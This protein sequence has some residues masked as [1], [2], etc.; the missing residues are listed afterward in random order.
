MKLVKKLYLFRYAHHS[1]HSTYIHTYY[2][3]NNIN[4]QLP[5]FHVKKN[6]MY[7]KMILQGGLRNLKNYLI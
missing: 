6:N 5:M 2:S 7:H 1:S 3:F 4:T